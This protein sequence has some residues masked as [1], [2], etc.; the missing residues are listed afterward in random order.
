MA[1]HKMK[2]KKMSSHREAPQ[3]AKRGLKTLNFLELKDLMARTK[4]RVSIVFGNEEYQIPKSEQKLFVEALLETMDLKGAQKN[5]AIL[6]TQEVADILNVSRPFVVKL[7]E[8]Q[9]LKS[10]N[11]GSH[12]RVLEVDALAFRQKMRN[13]KNVALDGLAEETENL[14][15]EFK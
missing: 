11:V 10:F 6:S 4:R 7:I 8:T 14:G 12:R 13:A 3:L 2:Q 15:L 1:L 5:G 9:Q